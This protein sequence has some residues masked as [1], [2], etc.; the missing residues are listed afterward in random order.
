MYTGTAWR[1]R[2]TGL[3]LAADEHRREATRLVL[4]SVARHSVYRYDR[5]LG[6]LQARDHE[7]RHRKCQGLRQPLQHR[8]IQQHSGDRCEQLKKRDMQDTMTGRSPA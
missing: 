1:H 4:K 7:A 6:H 2:L 3:N 5:V 8:D